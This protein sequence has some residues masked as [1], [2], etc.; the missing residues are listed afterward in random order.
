MGDGACHVIEEALRD[1]RIESRPGVSIVSIDRTGAL[2]STGEQIA[3]ATVIWCGGMRANPLA[4][5]LPG[6]HDR[7]GRVAVDRFLRVDGAA[8]IFAAGDA[9]AAGS[10]PG[11]TR[12]EVRR[13][14]S[15]AHGWTEFTSRRA[16][17]S[18]RS[19][20]TS[21]ARVRT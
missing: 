2:L 3:A 18:P 16:F 14:R 8:E 5:S 17:S 11:S 6:R 9:A 19:K 21:S 20:A 4:A 13:M 1:L 7:F 10:I 15:P 12:E